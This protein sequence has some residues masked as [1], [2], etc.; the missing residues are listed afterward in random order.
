MNT[1][2]RK[3]WF[4][5]RDKSRYTTPEVNV[6]MTEAMQQMII[7]I[8]ESVEIFYEPRNKGEEWYVGLADPH[9]QELP[10]HGH[11]SSLLEGL[12]WLRTPW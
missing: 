6:L 5:R 8:G 11:F 2:R 4:A 10:L 9:G 3:R 1:K 7:Q 12:D